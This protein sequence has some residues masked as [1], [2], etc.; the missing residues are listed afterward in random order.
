MKVQ[1]VVFGDFKNAE[2]PKKEFEAL[3]AKL[4]G[5]KIP[6][7][8]YADGKADPHILDIQAGENAINLKWFGDSVNSQWK[9][10]LEFAEALKAL[11]QK[12]I[13]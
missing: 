1:E 8:E 5:C 13:E 11:K 7:P 12:Y 4:E 6:F 10:V 9:D 2:F 3:V